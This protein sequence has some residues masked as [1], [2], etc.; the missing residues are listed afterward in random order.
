MINVKEY[1]IVS[2]DGDHVSVAAPTRDDYYPTMYEVKKEI[3]NSTSQID[4]S[5]YYTK[6]EIDDKG[7]LTSLPSDVVRYETDQNNDPCIIMP[8]GTKLTVYH[9]DGTFQNLIFFGE[10]EDGTKQTEVGAANTHLNLNSDSTVT[11]DTPNG[12]KTLAYTDQIPSGGSSYD[13]FSYTEDFAS[14]NGTITDEV[15][16]RLSAARNARQP[17]VVAMDLAVFPT[18]Y[19]CVIKDGTNEQQQMTLDVEFP[20]IMSTT[21][22]AENYDLSQRVL[23]IDNNKSVSVV[24][25]SFTLKSEGDGSLFL[26][27][28][29]TYKEISS[30]S[31]GTP[32]VNHGT[33]DTTFTLT[34]NVLHTW[35]EVSSLNLSFAAETTGI[36]NEYLFQFTSGA[37]ATVL[38]LPDAVKWIS[39]DTIEANKTYQ[40]SIVN[41]LAVMGGA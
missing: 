19:I 21:Y 4:L 12:K 23:Q 18:S 25:R 13:T 20:V 39:E 7:Y 1:G 16:D 37:T 10:Y 28:D 17:I 27:D 8:E 35:G 15:Y 11:V 32:V 14:G 22:N 3:K 9:Q 38:T 30:G 36:V 31:A 33:S 24:N 34:P 5:D 2:T 29:G 6:Q 26:A 40:V 41:N